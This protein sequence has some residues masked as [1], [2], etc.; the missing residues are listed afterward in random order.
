MTLSRRLRAVTFTAVAGSLLAV[1]VLATQLLASASAATTLA[2]SGAYT[3]NYKA[4]YNADPTQP[5]LRTWLAMTSLTANGVTSRPASLP[6]TGQAYVAADS[7]TALRGSDGTLATLSASTTSTNVV[8]NGF[9][10][11]DANGDFGLLVQERSR[12]ALKTASIHETLTLTVGGNAVATAGADYAY[13][14]AVFNAPATSIEYNGPGGRWAV[15][16]T[17]TRLNW[18]TT[19]PATTTDVSAPVLS[20][21]SMPSSTSTRAITI[22]ITATDNVAVTQ[23]R[24]ANEDGIWSAWQTF[25][26]S[27]SWTLSSSASTSK[28]VSTQVRDAAGN[29]STSIYRTLTY[30]GTTAT[31]DTTAPVLSGVTMPA[32]TATRTISIGLTASDNVGVAQMRFANEDGVWSAWR[33][34]AATATWT[35]SASTSAYK[36]VSAQ[37]RDAAGNT[38]KSIYTK[39]TF[40]G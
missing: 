16:G 19:A 22:G 20:A 17:L 37:V 1:P 29:E 21:V 10:R 6:A 7:G 28:G 26:P 5:E 32:T 12:E 8:G 18:E 3:D 27:M 40:T 14:G 38:S 25:A 30:T 13:D 24:F 4:S 23:A 33:P 36:G 9:F 35:L 11:T 39:I 15:N 2:A 31:A 34:F